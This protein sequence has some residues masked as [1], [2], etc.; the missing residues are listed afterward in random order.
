MAFTI[1]ILD[2]PVPKDW[3]QQQET[4]VL[5]EIVIDKFS[6]RFHINTNYWSLEDYVEQ[7]LE[8]IRSIVKSGDHAKSVLVTQFYDSPESNYAAMCWSLYRQGDRVN[9]QNYFEQTS[10]LSYPIRIEELYANIPQQQDNAS[11]WSV[12]LQ[13]LQDWYAELKLA[14]KFEIRN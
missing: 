11:E 7:W 14:Y 10:D 1:R 3:L 13:E 6:E 9:I 4:A 8:A 12:S 2:D 5:A